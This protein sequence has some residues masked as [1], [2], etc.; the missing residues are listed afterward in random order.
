VITF[1]AAAAKNMR[2]KISDFNKPDLYLPYKKQPKSIR[3]MHS[4]GYKII[5]ENA[6]EIGLKDIVKVV[7]SDR[8]RNILLGDAA[9]LIGYDRNDSK[10]TSQCRQFGACNFSSEDNKCLICIAYKNILR[11]CSAIDYD[12]Q[13]LLACN[14]LKDNPKLLAKYQSQCRHL[15]IDEYQD[16][17]EIQYN[18][19]MPILENLNRGNLFIVGDEKQSIYMF[20]D[21][22][23]EIFDTDALTGG[24]Y[25]GSSG[26]SCKATSGCTYLAG[27]TM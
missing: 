5:R 7:T 8:L 16:T 13:I 18:I 1:T 10:E 22:E 19:F 9:Q 12:E 15:L 14:L 17:N 2:D 4:L 26:P 6:T 24:S 25:S 23:L 11:S 27:T 3:T 20:R 21:A